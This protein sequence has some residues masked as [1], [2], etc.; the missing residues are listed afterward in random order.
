ML[1]DFP[2]ISYLTNNRIKPG[3]SSD[4][5]SNDG[6]GKTEYQDGEPGTAAE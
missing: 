6:S 4:F 3:L 5:L 2:K 1:A